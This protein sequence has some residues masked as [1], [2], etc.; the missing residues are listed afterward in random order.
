MIKEKKIFLLAGGNWRSPG[1][2]LPVFK[3][4]LPQSGKDNPKVAYIGTASGDNNEFFLRLSQLIMAAGAGNV[5]LVPIVQEFD[6]DKARDIML[7]S[8]IVFISGGD[9]HLGMKYLRSRKLVSFFREIY[10]RGNIFC[11]IS[12]GTIMLGRNWIH[13][14]DPDDDGQPRPNHRH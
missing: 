13:W 2:I 3:K 8:D 10:D 11:G 7:S 4:I 6:P 14:P 12:A 5:S 1:A 9:V